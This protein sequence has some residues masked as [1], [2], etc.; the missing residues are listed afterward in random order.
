MS[1]TPAKN[2][3]INIAN[4]TEIQL[5]AKDNEISAKDKEISDLKSVCGEHEKA[6]DQYKK[7]YEAKCIEYESQINTLKETIEE[8]LK[9]SEVPEEESQDGSQGEQSPVKPTVK[10]VKGKKK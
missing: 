6:I 10:I 4:Q 8:L 3:T 9:P 2:Y 5:S 7:D 1:R